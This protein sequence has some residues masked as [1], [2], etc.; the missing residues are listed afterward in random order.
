MQKT[1]KSTVLF[2]K[3]CCVPFQGCL[4]TFIFVLQKEKH[5]LIYCKLLVPLIITK[6]KDA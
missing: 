4:F 3:F 6:F 1:F 2:S 5:A